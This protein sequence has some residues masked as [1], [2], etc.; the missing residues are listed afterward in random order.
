MDTPLTSLRTRSGRP[1]EQI[2]I[3]DP[4][5]A[6]DLG[7]FPAKAIVGEMFAVEATVFRH[8]HERIRVALHVQAPGD[9]P[10][11]EIAMTAVNPGLDRWRASVLLTAPG[12]YRCTI[13]AWTDHF[14]S[15]VR[16]LEQ[17]VAAA[18]PDVASE[19]AE[20]LAQVQRAVAAAAPGD[21]ADIAALFDRLTGAAADPARLV[22]IAADR[23]AQDLVARTAPRADEVRWEPA[24]EVMAD[25]P[26]AR[27]GAWYELFV[28]SQGTKPGVSGT[29]ADAERRLR[30]IHALGFDV[31]YLAP[32][33]PIGLTNRK[34]ANNTVRANP[35]D[36]GSPWAIGSPAGGHTAIEPALGT[37][38]D[39][40]RFVH[41]AGALGM[42]VALD[43]AIQCSPDH[44][45]VKDHP[46][47]FYRRPDGTIRFAENPPK[48]YEDIYPV[49]F[50]TAD[51]RRLWDALR[52]V[53]RFWVSHGVKIFRVDNPH[54]KPIGFW[55]WL[56]AEIHRESPEAIFLAEA[57]TR[58]PMMRGLGKRGFT[59]SYT[60]FTWRNTKAELT[61]YL[62]ELLAPDMASSYRPNF[63]ANTP[64]ILPPILQQGGRPA[65]KSR[66]VLAA[67][68]SPSYGIYSG[69]ELCENAAIPGREE[70]L[71]SEKYEI[72]VRDW[73]AP[74]NLNDFIRRVNLAR[75]ENP[76]LHLFDNLRFLQV[77]DEHLL[78]YVK[79][80]PGHTH[81][82]IVVVNLDPFAAH[83]STV[84]VP[85]EVLGLAPGARYEVR[86]VMTDQR[87]EW[88]ESNFVSLDPVAGEP[89][90]VFVV[91]RPA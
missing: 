74:G 16:E 32:I 2:V 17:R 90:H 71:H 13:V 80:T 84:H 43:L 23:A 18:Q 40:D 81:A 86:D 11:I 72:K 61:E 70:Y 4:A 62:T 34:G 82:V 37:L 78:A 67:T 28:R 63:F 21:A 26:L 14:A 48:K 42:E 30:D 57:F 36:P 45:W 33:H 50:D 69:Y 49:N 89:A 68:L 91:R 44:P 20:G 31:V 77:D 22:A 25:R 79:S 41:A 55:T 88:G 3:E 87:Y 24:L 1:Y 65:F 38:D 58:P 5:P 75:R 83:A 9:G 7:R 85:A 73:Q 59:Q 8:G 27:T 56:I 54:T 39:F 29:F 35:G 19:V 53:V 15:W 52:E 10:P 60:Y 76:A 12:R 66:L 6:V 51:W 46:D 47:W 64:D